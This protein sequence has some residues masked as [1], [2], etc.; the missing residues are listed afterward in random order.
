[1]AS[2]EASSSVHVSESSLLSREGEGS[3][4]DS[5]DKQPSD[6]GSDEHKESHDSPITERNS[7]NFDFTEQ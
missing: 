6:H 5:K 2:V 1:M 3:K 7:R 4:V